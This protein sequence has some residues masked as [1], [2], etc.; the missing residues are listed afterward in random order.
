MTNLS[1]WFDICLST[2]VTYASP[3]LLE[4]F[5]KIKVQ[6]RK[7]V[8]LDSIEGAHDFFDQCISIEKKRFVDKVSL[9]HCHSSDFNRFIKYSMIDFG[10]NM[11]RI[12]PMPTND[13]RT[14]FVEVVVQLWKYFGNLTGLLSFKWCE[15]KDKRAASVIF[16]AKQK[17]ESTRLLDGIGYNDKNEANMII[18]SSGLNI[19]ANLDHTLQDSLKNIKSTTDALMNVMCRY[20]NASVTTLKKVHVYSVQTIQNTMTAI[21]YSLKDRKRW[22]AFEC[23]SI[24]LPMVYEERKQLIQLYEL[25]LLE[26]RKVFERLEDEHLGYFDVDAN[27]LISDKSKQV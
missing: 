18:E 24:L 2:N 10:I 12:S 25:D 26:Q 8:Y 19:V 4:H 14:M 15:K 5:R 16:F 22:R 23:G 11:L 13:E 21:Q 9:L 27:D 1:K 7:N 17:K 3:E 20:S 6:H